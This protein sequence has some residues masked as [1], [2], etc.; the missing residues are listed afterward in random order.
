MWVDPE[1]IL[2]ND[3][4][5]PE[6]EKYS[7][8]SLICAILKKETTNKQSKNKLIETETK[9]MDNKG[10]ENGVHVKKTKENIIKNIVISLHN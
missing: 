5:Q 2:L 9:V 10:E 8:V 4:S 3:I 6:K 1:D 7:M